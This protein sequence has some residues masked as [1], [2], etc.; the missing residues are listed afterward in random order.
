GDGKTAQE[1]T[2]GK[3]TGKAYRESVQGKRTGQSSFNDHE[4][5][6]SLPHRRGSFLATI[7]SWTA[8]IFGQHEQEGQMPHDL[9]ATYATSSRRAS[10]RRLPLCP[11]CGDMLLAPEHSEF[12]GAGRIQHFWSCE[13][14]GTATETTVAIA[15]TTH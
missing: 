7:A 12:H 11:Q 10:L 1:R 2:Q 4:T 5:V 13:N 3:R 8:R 15:V 6:L 14:C 9:D